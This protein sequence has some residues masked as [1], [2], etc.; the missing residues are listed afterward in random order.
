M[1]KKTAL[2]I[3]SLLWMASAQSAPECDIQLN[4]AGY[5]DGDTITANV[6]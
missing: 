5:N 1:L 3:C 4:Q 6:F 2:L